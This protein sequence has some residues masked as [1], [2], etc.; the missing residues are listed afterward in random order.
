[1]PLYFQ[2]RLYT[3]NVISFFHTKDE[4]KHIDA[5]KENNV[6]SKVQ[7]KHSVTH[8]RSAEVENIVLAKEDVTH[9]RSA[10]TEHIILAKED[11]TH[12]RST[13]VIVPEA[14]V[15]DDHRN[16]ERDANFSAVEKSMTND[17]AHYV[18]PADIVVDVHGN[19]ERDANVRA[20]I[21]ITTD[22]CCVLTFET[23]KALLR[24]TTSPE[25]HFDSIQIESVEVDMTKSKDDHVKRRG[26]K[27]RTTKPTG[28]NCKNKFKINKK[29]KKNS[30][31]IELDILKTDSPNIP[32]PMQASA[33]KSDQTK[34]KIYESIKFD[35]QIQKTIYNH[36]LEVIHRLPGGFFIVGVFFVNNNKIPKKHSPKHLL[37]LQ[38]VRY[39]VR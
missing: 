14:I 1:M 17:G 27:E 24:K 26:T 30:S 16:P 33:L 15:G 13:D 9:D 23:E 28:E 34:G 11:V 6:E 5:S 4:F 22:N 31:T 36:A 7:V 12:Y 2:R 3:Y 39:L 38:T 19:P 10:E 8:G 21:G 25:N 20:D 37:Q 18:V 32:G 35:E 29:A